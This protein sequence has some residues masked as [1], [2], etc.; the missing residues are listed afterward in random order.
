LALR[1]P[2]FVHLDSEQA[3]HNAV[4]DH[5]ADQL[6]KPRL[7]ADR[8]Y[9]FV[10]GHWVEVQI[11][12]QG[13]ELQRLVVDYGGAGLELQ[14]VFLRRF[15]IHGDQ[16]VDLLLA[17][18]V[19]LLAGADGEPG[20]QAGDVGREQVLA[21]N[22][23]AHLKQGAHQDGVGGLAAGAVDSGH[24]DREIVD[25]GRLL[26]ARRRQDGTDLDG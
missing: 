20:W 3:R 4:V 5:V 23:N 9:Q 24:L 17:A 11:G 10:E 12:P 6:A 26:L 15:R 1:A 14:G 22:R 8:A 25:N 21:G 18:D 16:E 2:N 13:V 19:T 7:G